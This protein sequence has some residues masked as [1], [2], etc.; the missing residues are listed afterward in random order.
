MIAWFARNDVAANLLL[1]T[2]VL[3]GLYSLTQNLA[4]EV[5]PDADPDVISVFVPL[6]GATPEDVELGV[7]MRIEEAVHEL[8]GVEKIT[9]RSVEGSTTVQIEVDA[10]YD[11]RDLLNDVKNQVD[12]INTFPADT[13]KPIVSLASHKHGVIEVVVAGDYSEQ[14][15][16]MLAEQVRDDLLRIGGITQVRLQSVRK[17]EIAIE[18]SQDRLREFTL[19]LA[20][21]SRAIRESSLDISAGN[22][23][24][25]GGDVLIRSKGQA[26]RQADFEEIVVKTNPDGT[27]IR[28][29]DVAEVLDS[30]QE[31]SVDTR[32]DGRA[33]AFVRVERVGRQ[34]ALEISQL[35]KD[36]IARRQETLPVGV[37]LSYW[38]DNARLLET[39]LGVLKSSAIQG[40]ILVIILLTLFLRPAIA[41]W[42]FIGI[43]ISFLGACISMALFDISI[44]LMSAYGFIIVLGIVVDDAIVTGENVYR[45]LQTSETGLEAAINGTHEIAMPVT[46]GVLTTIAAFTPLAFIEGRMGDVFRSIPAVVIPVLL[47][48]LIESKLVLPSHLKHSKQRSADKP[49]SRLSQWQQGIANGLEGFI[50]RYYQ[51][52]LRFAIHHRYSTLA[53]FCGVL[54]IIVAMIVSGWT[55]FVFFPQVE[56]ETAR[57]TLIMPVGTPFEVT[58]RHIQKIMRT[59]LVMQSKY[60]DADTGES[61]IQHVFSSSGSSGRSNGSNFGQVQFEMVPPESRPL[62]VTT[63]EVLS[64]WRRVIGIV[65]GAE[66]LTYRSNIFRPG[67]PIDVQFSASTFE[68]LEAVGNKVKE[69]LTTYPGVFDIADSLSDGKEELRVELTRQGHVLGLTRADIVNQVGQA[70]KGFEAQRIQ[71]GRDDIRVLVRFPEAERST[72]DTLNEMLISAPNGRRVPFAHV[73]ELTPGKGPSRITRIDRYR[74]LNVTAD[75]DKT[76]TNMTVLQADLT[77][78]VEQLLLQYPGV[79]YK[80]E[81]EARHQRESFGSLG[82]GLAILMFVIYCL[83]ALPLKSYVQPLI[84]MAIIPFGM[85]GATLGHWILGYDISILSI[86]GLMALIGVVVNDSLVLVDF[87]NKRC[88]AGANIST[89]VMEGGIIRFRPIMLTSLTTFF[90]LLPMMLEKSTSSQFLIPMGISLSFGI[91]FATA[92]TLLL[93]PVNILI[94]EDIKTAVDGWWGGDVA[95]TGDH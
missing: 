52:L 29:S 43:P 14:E 51:P 69:R 37:T 70:F 55:K 5:F 36:Y 59:A 76:N 41:F 46:F 28:I 80:L 12:S 38:D 27:I 19:T 24:T 63:T 58:D 8:E 88:I 77:G 11:P 86:L 94:W 93:V 6:R 85:I 78:Y 7:A 83:L 39:R 42:V 47:F 62:D 3:G 33:A 32:F 26:Y 16:R 54:A 67:D 87:I 18:A 13:E 81:G 65:P 2:V 73:A 89:A 35:V 17:Y 31:E 75:I 92:I 45:H 48:S 21:L 72:I 20:D 61:V 79:T 74:T 1:V 22:V 56:S 90:G 84:I 95:A 66:S 49:P 44:N 30:F 50:L 64:E 10:S 15:I 57:A 53:T 71:R 25:D 60:R 34:S 9:S 91:L 4:F 68:V 82:A 40:G 23:R